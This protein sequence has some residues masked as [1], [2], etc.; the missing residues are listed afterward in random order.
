[1]SQW[2]LIIDCLC[3]PFLSWVKK[4]FVWRN[5]RLHHY[6]QRSMFLTWFESD[7]NLIVLFWVVLFCLSLILTVNLHKDST[8]AEDKD[9]GFE[10]YG[11]CFCFV[12]FKHF[13]WLLIHKKTSALKSANGYQTMFG[14]PVCQWYTGPILLIILVWGITKE[15]FALCYGSEA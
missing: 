4:V 12:F 15:L 3:G 14:M 9:F 6:M 2:L 1:M 11:F 5:I 7:S 10:S 13:W 8:W